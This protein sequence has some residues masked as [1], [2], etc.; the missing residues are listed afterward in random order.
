[1]DAI[2]FSAA[3]VAAL[4]VAACGSA[5]EGGPRSVEQ[6]Y[7][8]IG[9]ASTYLQIDADELRQGICETPQGRYTITTFV[10]EKGKRDWLDYAQMWGGIYLVGELWAVVAKPDLLENLQDET[11]GELE[12]ISA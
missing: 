9:C 8:T 2:K 4:L 1:M 11:G 5:P 7:T 6:M 3:L 10:T 12:D